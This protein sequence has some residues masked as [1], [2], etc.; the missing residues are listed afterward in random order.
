VEWD[1]DN[2]DPEGKLKIKDT[3]HSDIC[4][5]VLYAF[6]ESCHWLYEAPKHDI[7]SYTEEWYKKEQD[8]MWNQAW[9]RQKSQEDDE[10]SFY[11]S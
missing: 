9:E 1:R 2:K 10:D 4:D 3:F 6:R 5:A 7:K 8:E 11:L